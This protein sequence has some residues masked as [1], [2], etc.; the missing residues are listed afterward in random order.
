MT[1]IQTTLIQVFPGLRADTAKRLVEH[2]RLCEYPVETM[3][4]HEGNVETVFFIILA[5]EVDIMTR[6]ADGTSRHLARLGPG[7]FFGEMALIEDKPRSATVT[8]ISTVTVLEIS[9]D[10]FTSLLTQ[11]PVIAYAILQTVTANLRAADRAAIKDLSRK[12]AELAQA[13]KDLKAAQE[14]LVARERMARDL[15]IAR[16]VQQSLLPSSFPEKEGWS[17]HGH[18]DPARMVG[19][20]Y[21]DAI[22]LD[23]DHVALLLADV[24]DKSVH[25]ALYMA[26]LR[27]LFVAEAKRHPS[28]SETVLAV[29][30]GYL[31][32][33][34]L[35]SFATAFYGVLE[36]STGMLQY[37]RAGHESPLLLR[38]RGR[39]IEK[40]DADGRL[41]GIYDGLTLEQRETTL[42]PGDAL[43]IYSD[44]VT[45]ALDADGNSY[46]K[47]RF[48]ATAERFAGILARKVC[49]G[50]FEDIYRFRGETEATDD[51]TLLVATR[52]APGEEFRPGSG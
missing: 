16:D 15:E 27:T 26:V 23:D 49:D 21:M 19:G 44:G 33:A 5:G 32:A 52:L 30:D 1:D 37:V 51:I 13:L 43:L 2:A 11:V 35:N 25:A 42:E 18:N 10:T 17:I 24:A 31:A 14:E 28:P 34:G 9:K 22:E 38:D 48:I 20:D 4:C 40:L 6:M 8:T 47:E 12:N 45:D 41:L 7:R 46:G 3:L 39:R 29:H 50:I 36:F